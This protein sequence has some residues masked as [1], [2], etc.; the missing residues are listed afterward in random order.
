MFWVPGERSPRAWATGRDG[1][2]G[3]RVDAAGRLDVCTD[4]GDATRAKA[5]RTPAL[6]IQLCRNRLS[7]RVRLLPL[8]QWHGCATQYAARAAPCGAA[9]AADPAGTASRR[10]RHNGAHADIF[11]DIRSDKML[12]WQTTRT[13]PGRWRPSRQGIPVHRPAWVGRHRTAGRASSHGAQ[14]APWLSSQCQAGT[15]RHGAGAASW[16]SRRPAIEGRSMG[17]VPALLAPN[18]CDGW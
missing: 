13:H 7:L 1:S 6:A 2:G 12:R 9:S 16:R 8:P 3:R 15:L 10:K 14:V 4:E 17:R 5:L 11:L 18:G